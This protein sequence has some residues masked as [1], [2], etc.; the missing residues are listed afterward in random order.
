MADYIYRRPTE[1]DIIY[2]TKH[3]RKEDRREL[4]GMVGPDIEKEIRHCITASECAY[5]CSLEGKTLAAFGVICKNPMSRHGIIWMLASEE[6]AKHKLYTGKWTK[7]GIEA[8]LNDW[9]FLYNYVDEGNDETIKWLKWIG[10]KVYPPVPRGLYGR[11]Y[12]LFTFTR[13]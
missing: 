7:K 12:H 8:F 9:E 3:L 11:N 4:T 2:L 13:K 1:E 10:A 6:T 5:A